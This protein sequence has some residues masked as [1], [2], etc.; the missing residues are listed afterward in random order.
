MSRFQHLDIVLMLVY[1]KEA[2]PPF[3]K[4]SNFK[5]VQLESL[6]G[7]LEDGGLVVEAW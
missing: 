1:T 3:N 5:E 2:N 4:S 6:V 7:D